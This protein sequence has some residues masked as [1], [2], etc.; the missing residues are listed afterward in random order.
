MFYAEGCD[1][2]DMVFIDRG[3]NIVR[4]RLEV[5]KV[6]SP[7]VSAGASE[8]DI[9]ER[10]TR[11][12]DRRRSELSESF[13]SEDHGGR[14][15]RLAHVRLMAELPRVSARIAN[16]VALLNDRLSDYELALQVDIADHTPFAEAKHTVRVVGAREEEPSLVI[17]IDHTGVIRFLL[18]N[19]DRRALLGTDT[20]GSLHSAHVMD[21]LVTLLEAHY[22]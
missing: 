18:K 10:L 12:V 21:M 8:Q 4:V 13:V 2:S 11:I 19:G 20:V 3:T 15:R 22:L 16:A 9:D 14:A 17:T 1:L 5:T 6:D 7:T